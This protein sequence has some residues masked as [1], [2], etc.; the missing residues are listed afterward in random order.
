M[1]FN[2]KNMVGADAERIRAGERIAMRRW[3]AKHDRIAEYLVDNYLQDT[4]YLVA[5]VRKLGGDPE[6]LQRKGRKMVVD[7]ICKERGL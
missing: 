7:A 1:S 3:V 6:A 4:E 5:A 2:L